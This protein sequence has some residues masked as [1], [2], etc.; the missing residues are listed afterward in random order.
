MIHIK[1]SVKEREGQIV[2]T[3]YYRNRIR[4]K[5]TVVSLDYSQQWSPYEGFRGIMQLD[6]TEEEF[7]TYINSIYETGDKGYVIIEVGNLEDLLKVEKE[8]ISQ[9][10]EIV[11]Y[12]WQGTGFNLKN[13]TLGFVKV[14]HEFS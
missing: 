8:S 4:D 7:N 14:K 9:V 13:Q 3:D 11:D 10:P 2:N 5:F 6:T 1:I 12:K